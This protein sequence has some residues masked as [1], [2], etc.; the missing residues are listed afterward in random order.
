MPTKRHVEKSVEITVNLGEMQFCKLRST[1]S[2]EF[3]YDT[4]EQRL[5]KEKE[6]WSQV[7]VDIRHSLIDT[8]NILKKKYDVNKFFT[9]VAN[10]VDGKADA[11]ETQK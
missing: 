7:G 2:E 10:K 1:A 9:A 8:L 6:L 3:E 4:E 5:A 11:K